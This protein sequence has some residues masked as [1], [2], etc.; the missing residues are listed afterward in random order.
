MPI[1]SLLGC[2][3]QQSL[4]QL[5]LALDAVPRPG[6]GLQSLGVDLLA[7]VNT[8]PEAA[9]AD[10][11]QRLIHHLQKLPLVVA[12]A[13]QEFLGVGAGGAVGD[14]LSG[15]LIG[16]AAVLLRAGDGATQLLLP[17]FQPLLE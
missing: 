3:F 7:A 9:F 8:F 17:R 2:L 11:H 6:H 15:V 1:P 13:E 16:R 14:V 12:L 5:L 4:L 10:A